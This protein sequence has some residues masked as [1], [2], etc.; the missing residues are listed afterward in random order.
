M[1]VMQQCT[2]RHEPENVASYTSVQLAAT[3]GITRAFGYRVTPTAR[4]ADA[5]INASTHA[6]IDRGALLLWDPGELHLMREDRALN[7]LVLGE[8]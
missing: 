4:L 8:A 6:A 1:R 5:A 7:G 3:I 2:S